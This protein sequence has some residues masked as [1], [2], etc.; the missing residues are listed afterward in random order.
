MDP[1][2]LFGG[3]LLNLAVAVLI[4]RGIFYPVERDKNYVFTFL[5]FS[6]TIYFVVVFISTAEVSLGVGFGLFAIFS[7]LRYRTASVSAREMTYLFVLIGLPVMNSVLIRTGEWV[8]LAGAN[9]I[10]VVVIFVLER[11]WGFKYEGIKRIRYDRADL[12]KPEHRAL[13]LEDLRER[14]G[15]QIK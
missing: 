13:L 1:V 11:G 9:I 10:I 6:T 7:V 15:L 3:F 8:N 5:A 4:V 14:T 2:S 12:V